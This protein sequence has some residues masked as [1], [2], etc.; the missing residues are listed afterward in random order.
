[1][2]SRS[3]RKMYWK[4]CR[5]FLKGLQMKLLIISF[6]SG[7]A[8]RL[9]CDKRLYSRLESR[10]KIFMKMVPGT[11]NNLVLVKTSEK[12]Q[13]SR[14]F[15]QNLFMGKVA[16]LKG[17]RHPVPIWGDTICNDRFQGLQNSN[18]LTPQKFHMSIPKMAIFKR[19]H[20]FQGLTSFWGPKTP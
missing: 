6:G 2:T 17:H 7:F 18:K 20:L 8:K 15:H 1:M 4:V 11:A 14:V 3:L 10:D 5:E 19:S 9:G 16:T 13:K 12:D